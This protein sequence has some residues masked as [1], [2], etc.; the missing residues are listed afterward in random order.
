MKK[1][2][3]RTAQAAPKKASRG[4]RQKSLEGASAAPEHA[5]AAPRE[6]VGNKELVAALRALRKGDFSVRLPV[7]PEGG[8]GQVAE[9]FNELSAHLAQLEGDTART[10][11]AAAQQGQLGARISRGGYRG[12]FRRV[13]D[14][15]NALLEALA[16]YSRAV[17]TEA[18]ALSDGDF[19]RRKR[20][21]SSREWPGQLAEAPA[22]LFELRA[23]LDRLG[24]EARRVAR[25]VTGQGTLSARLDLG[26]ASSGRWVELAEAYNAPLALLGDTLEA[27]GANLV[28]LG[29]GDF[30]GR[31]DA[32]PRGGLRKLTVSINRFF[33]DM[34]RSVDELVGF[35]QA[36]TS[37]GRL[38]RPLR[39]STSGGKW[40]ELRNALSSMS[41]S[42]AEHH[43]EL[44][45][46]LRA[47]ASGD[48]SQR[49]RSPMVGDL[50]DLQ[51]DANDLVEAVARIGSGLL[52][53]HDRLREGRGVEES[54][55][56][57]RS[58]GLWRELEMSVVS[59]SRDIESHFTGAVDALRALA[60]GDFSAQIP[61]EAGG[62][63]AE[64]RAAYAAA[65]ASLALL[66]AELDR[67]CAE[68][69]GEGNLEARA[70]GERLSGEYSKIAT[71]VNRMASVAANQMR[72]VGR[73]VQALMAGS[74]SAKSQ[75]EAHGEMLQLQAALNSLVD[76]LGNLFREV[77][78]L[79]VNLRE[80]RLG[81]KVEVVGASGEYR[82]LVDAVNSMSSTLTQQLRSF[83]VVASASARGDLTQRVRAEARGEVFEL[84]ET[85][86]AMLD[87]L[88]VVATEVTRV[89]W[90]VGTEGKLGV[91]ASAEGARGT[92][93]DL[94]EAVNVMAS[95]LTGQV[96]DIAAATLA[97]A[98]GDLNRKVSVNARGELL[99]LKQTVNAMIDQLGT[100]AEQVTR[101]TR[102]V[103]IEGK[104]GGQARLPG[105]HG[106]WKELADSVN[107][108]VSSFTLQVRSISAVTTAV[109]RGDLSRRV[110]A[111]VQ[112][113]PLALKESIN[114]MV[115][116]VNRFALEVTRV[117]REVGTDGKLGG[118]AALSGA[119]GLWADLTTSVNEMARNLSA[120]VRGIARVVTGVARGDLSMRLQLDARGEIATLVETINDMIGTLS[121]FT[122][123]VGGVARDVGVEGRLGGQA[124]VPGAAGVWRVL[125]ENVNQLAANL[126]RQVRS[127]TEVATAVTEGDLSRT[128]DVEA[129]GEVAQLTEDV[130]R[131]IRELEVSKTR[132]QEQNW[133]KTELARFTRSFQ[134]QEEVAVLTRQLL[135]DMADS[136]GVGYGAF[137]APDP[138]ADPPRLVCVASFARAGELAPRGEVGVGEGLLGEAAGGRR[139][140]VIDSPPGDYVSIRTGLGEAKPAQIVIVPV[141][142][143]SS[144]QGVVELGTLS[145]LSSVQHSFLVQ[146]VETLGI[147]LSSLRSR[148]RTTALLEQS[149]QL[150]EEL[151]EQKEELRQANEQLQEKA[152]L[153]LSRNE[154]VES[155]NQQIELSRQALVEKADQLQT[156]SRYKSQFLANMSHELRTPLNSLLILARQLSENKGGRL[157]PREVDY[158]KT[159]HQSGT[160]LLELINE[161]LDLAK[162]ES[163][164]MEVVEVP[165]AL[166][167]LVS[168][169][170][171][172]F[173]P[174]A[175]ERGLAFEVRVDQDAP[176]ML[177]TDE[178]RVMQVLRNLLSN[179]FKFTDSG[180]VRLDVQY[181]RRRPGEVAFMVR[182][183]GIGIEPDAQASVFEAFR[184]LDAGSNREYSGTGLGLAITRELAELLGGSIE[185]QSEVGVGSTFSFHL[186]DR[187]KSHP[188]P[189]LEAAKSPTVA[190]MREARFRWSKIPKAIPESTMEDDRDDLRPGDRLL[191]VVEDDEP[192]AGILMEIVRSHGFKV[193]VAQ[194][195][196]AAL[197]IVANMPVVAIT[198]D[199][200]LP[201]LDGWEIL[202]LLKA[203]PETRHI[204]VHIISAA[205]PTRRGL[206]LGAISVLSKPVE[207]SALETS[208]QRI[209]RWLDRQVRTLLIVEDDDDLRRAITDL[210]RGQDV[211]CLEASTAAKAIELLS[212]E[213]LDCVVMDLR[214][215]DE[216]GLGLVEKLISR[217]DLAVAPIVVYTGKELTAEEH[218]TLRTVARRIITKDARSQQRLYDEVAFFLHRVAGRVEP[219]PGDPAASARLG[220]TLSPRLGA[221]LHTEPHS[222]EAHEAGPVS[223]DI[224]AGS[225]AGEASGESELRCPDSEGGALKGKVALVVD[226]DIRNIFALTALLEDEGMEVVNA[227]GGRA[228]LEI[229]ERHPGIH[230]VLLD[231]MMPGMDG[232][233]TLRRIRDMESCRNLPV[234]AVTAK[235]MVADRAK[236]F[237]M[238]ASGYVAKPIDSDFLRRSLNDAIEF[239]APSRPLR[240][241]P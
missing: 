167:A 16:L 123:Q 9:A 234:I 103:S 46:V 177:R 133:L 90:E 63:F 70:E 228:A 151:R 210:L 148:M 93:R 66:S 84:K 6:A 126:T 175:Q 105:A 95:N 54:F 222:G 44:R 11:V 34:G 57:D 24:V 183:T 120:Q 18:Q 145:P 10:A 14:A 161:I 131:M 150:A 81:R 116:Q 193:V 195:G 8:T 106:V 19:E 191:L 137:Y 180:G 17:A 50:A 132:N 223:E 104:L 212:E 89:A 67:V 36:L 80:G 127:M 181:G 78:Q 138:H 31:L 146:L 143:Q 101:L 237:E 204:P 108:M 114:Q 238:G 111:E 185:L 42:L 22:A 160:D 216:P 164:T 144:L 119:Q 208:F 147:V 165:V 74:T 241:E 91:E 213:E 221:P 86:N 3:R 220:P 73:V 217:S 139:I 23:A 100:L 202:E 188:P 197:Q 79:A 171:R 196:Q 173:R 56:L 53:A 200:G 94:T 128:I 13:A 99:E 55:G 231:I 72:E 163:G 69:A 178:R 235:A 30:G 157:S 205:D 199:L 118:Q 209:Q 83:A 236:C 186:A 229:L 37:E 239:G 211:R 107:L 71:G 130:N 184:Q 98:R 172:S 140:L 136:L 225:A 5:R 12:G 51:K 134:G 41:A 192:F 198:L 174:I 59:V 28:A 125:T 77:A 25:E 82:D 68:F 219:A 65:V 230:A 64:L 38:G 169:C 15:H 60:Q 176:A 149:Q 179:A 190:G 32:A 40:N 154:E 33:D 162:I 214:L 102:D 21:R 27:V 43:R 113:E 58:S 49:S 233:K 109:A 232:Y 110:T 76:W 2:A 4:R 97:V 207:R 156:T 52:S 201:D 96:R 62:Q 159:I 170:E 206:E 1:A 7:P 47:A 112:G 194:T 203:N 135:V 75:V 189:S 224:E 87:Q 20:P 122:A 187:P 121:T 61:G 240:G 35:S 141:V 39:L 153:L 115:D 142:F 45:S 48:A 29:Q 226:D 155:K 182:D 158:A 129:R 117:A 124:E 85:M 152:R 92:W 227:E 26:D 218:A 168:A 88:S 215:P 166:D